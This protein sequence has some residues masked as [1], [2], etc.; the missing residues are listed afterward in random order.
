[1]EMTRFFVDVFI[2]GWR[3]VLTMSR[4]NTFLNWV[5][6]LWKGWFLPDTEYVVG[7]QSSLYACWRLRGYLQLSVDYVYRV[8]TPTTPQIYL[9]IANE[10]LAKI[11]LLQTWRLHNIKLFTFDNEMST[12]K[13]KCSHGPLSL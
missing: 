12:N 2:D 1:M 13:M 4:D 11:Q 3:I 7:Q 10:S 8:Y 6:A 9:P 5:S